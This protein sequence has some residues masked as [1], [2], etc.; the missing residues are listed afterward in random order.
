MLKLLYRTLIVVK[1]LSF[2][3]IDLNVTTGDWTALIIMTHMF[4]CLVPWHCLRIS[5][6]SSK[7]NEE[8]GAM[9]LKEIKRDT[10]LLCFKKRIGNIVLGMMAGKWMN[11]MRMDELNRK[12]VGW[13]AAKVP[14]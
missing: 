5:K 7:Q 1:H 2:T 11:G 9:L 13:F 12:V 4:Q 6:W 8:D 3:S 14:R 10:Q